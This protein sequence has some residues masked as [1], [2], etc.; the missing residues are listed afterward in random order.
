MWKRTRSLAHRLSQTPALLQTYNNIICDQ[1]NRGFIE[2]VYTPK[3]PGLTHFIPH[4][5]IKKN[6]ITTPICIVYDCSCCQSKDHPSFNDCLLTGPHFF[7]DLC[8]I[9]LC[10]RTHIYAISTNIEKAFLHIHLNESDRDYSRF[11]WLSDATD[12]KSELIMYRF[13]TV[14]FGAVSSPF[15]LYAALYHHLQH[16][17]T[18]LSHDIQANLYVDNV[19]SG[20]ETELAA[21]QYYKQ[22]RVIMSE[23]KF[24]LRS[25]VTT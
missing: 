2:R 7:N 5:C 18:P 10:F 25:W 8:S 12:P 24:N 23:A 6:S 9:I 13:E 3:I 16:Y 20:C 14:L 17:N 15:M 11:L 1:L 22:A 4:H 19:V 21:I